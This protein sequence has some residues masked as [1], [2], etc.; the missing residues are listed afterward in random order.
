MVTWFSMAFRIVSAAEKKRSF[1][2][3]RASVPS[4]SWQTL[5]FKKKAWRIRVYGVRK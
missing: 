1:V 4:L 2:T 5:T 3:F